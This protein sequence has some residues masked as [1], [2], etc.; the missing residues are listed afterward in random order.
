MD[1][2]GIALARSHQGVADLVVSDD[3]AFILRYG[4]IFLLVTGNNG[5]NALL[6]ISLGYN[7]ASHADGTE[8]ALVDN[9]RK[10]GTAGSDSC[11]RDGVKVNRLIHLD[12]FSMYPKDRL[13]AF[14]V[15][16][17]HRDPPV[18]TA[19]SQEGLIEGL[20][21]V[22]GRQDHNT[23]SSVESVHLCKKLV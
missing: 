8:R 11:S 18:E 6:Q 22:C 3:P 17:L 7:A 9:V 15:R 1:R 14:E 23:L 12:I 20:R 10:L 13:T 19:R 16:E 5:L 4:R 2:S 21:T